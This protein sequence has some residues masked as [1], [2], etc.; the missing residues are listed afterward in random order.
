MKTIAYQGVKGAFS[1]ITALKE[2]GENHH[3]RGLQTFKE[4]FEVVNRGEADDAVIPI[5]N[6]L[7][8]SIYENYDLL[9]T[10]EMKIVAE[11]FTKIEHCL[12]TLSTPHLKG[13]E[14]LKKITKVLSHP[15]ALE[16][17]SNFFQNHPWIE[18]VV[19]F[20]TAGAAAEIAS[21][22]NPTLAAIASAEASELYGLKILKKGI[23]DDPKNYTRFVTVTKREMHS[24]EIDKCSLLLQLKHCPG[25]LAELLKHFAEQAINLTKIESRPLRGCPFEYLFY[26]DFEFIGR[27]RQDIENLLKGLC[28]KVQ[29][30]KILGFYKKGAL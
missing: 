18:A 11:H 14:Q 5:E 19:H 13:D 2:F 15:K 27:K 9:N 4:V 8:G 1:Y 6:S 3:F 26:V 30:L 17:C 10:Y 25:A 12:L 16:Q 22:G 21:S 20:N 24:E 23:E 28:S 29:M 7:I